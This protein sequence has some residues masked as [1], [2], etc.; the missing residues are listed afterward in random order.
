MIFFKC[1]LLINLKFILFIK[2]K[3]E[4]QNKA[5]SLNEALLDECQRLKEENKR[6]K[7]MF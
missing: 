3:E 6:L 2:K 4:I 1:L 5:C 7:K